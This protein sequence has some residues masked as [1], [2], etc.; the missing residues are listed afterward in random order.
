[1]MKFIEKP[2]LPEGKVTSVICGKLPK[3]ISDYFSF[4]GIRVFRCSD[5]ILI[6]PAVK[7]HVDMAA[8]HLGGNTVVVDKG[9]VALGCALKE[10]GCDVILTEYAVSGKYPNDVKINVALF[11]NTAVGA[12]R[13]SDVN[14]LKAISQYKKIN[15]NQGYAKCSIL[16]VNE[17][18]VITDD[19]SVCKALKNDFD[20]LLISKGNIFLEGHEYG[21]IGGTAAKISESEILFFGNIKKHRDYEKIKDFL[22][23]HACREICFEGL[24]LT[25]FGGLVTLTEM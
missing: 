19:E 17:K 11:G 2:N 25:D 4:R 18:A 3:E 7:S 8:V 13:H 15:V 14:F 22:G 16:P 6:D 12:F 20:V 21:F 5:N 23:K 10:L 24:P 9:Q 1:M